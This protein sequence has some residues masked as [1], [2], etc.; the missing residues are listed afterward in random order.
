MLWSQSKVV[1][2]GLL[3]PLAVAIAQHNLTFLQLLYPFTKST[4][5]K[6]IVYQ[7]RLALDIA[8]LQPTTYPQTSTSQA[9][10]EHLTSPTLPIRLHER[11]QDA[12][13]FLQILRRHLQSVRGLEVLA[14]SPAILDHLALARRP[15]YN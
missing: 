8:T 2:W 7:S 5:T 4:T 12:I 15:L 6:S 11:F 10:I 3:C 13:P 9:Q 14:V 1:Q